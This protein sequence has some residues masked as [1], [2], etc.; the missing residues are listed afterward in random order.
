MRALLTLARHAL[1]ATESVSGGGRGVTHTQNTNHILLLLLLRKQMFHTRDDDTT[2]RFLLKPCIR[3]ALEP[4][5][6]IFT[7][8]RANQT[9]DCSVIIPGRQ[10]NSNFTPMPVLWF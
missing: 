6:E 4:A 3:F 10:L 1:A 2:L 9:S 5:T 8:L 7:S